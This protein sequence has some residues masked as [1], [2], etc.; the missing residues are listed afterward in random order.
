MPYHNEWSLNLK[1]SIYKSISKHFKEFV[2]SLSNT[3][4]FNSSTLSYR[5]CYKNKKCKSGREL[6]YFSY[7]SDR[8]ATQTVH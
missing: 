8:T 1:Y 6:V 2:S 5:M 4:I 3:E 7:Y